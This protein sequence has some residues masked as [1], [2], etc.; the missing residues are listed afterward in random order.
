MDNFNTLSNRLLNRAPKI[1]IVLASQFIND[2]WRTLQSRRQWSW[3]R[4]SGC[5]SPPNQYSTGTATSNLAAGN[6][7]LITGSGTTW[8]VSMVGRQIRLSGYGFPYY[9]IVAVLSTTAILIDQPWAGPDQTNASYQ[10]S[11]LWYPV[12]SDWGAWYS[13]TSPK[14]GY[15]L[16]T[17]VTEDELNVLDPQRTTSGQTYVVAFKDYTSQYGGIIGPIIPVAA[18]GA[19]PVSTTSTGYSYIANATYIVKIVAGGAAGTATWAWMRAGQVAFSSTVPSDADFAQDLDNGVQIYWPAG[20]YVANDLFVIN[21]QALVASGV[22]R[23]ELWPTPNTTGY[24][25]PYTYWAKEYDLTPEAPQLPGFVANRGEVL[26]QM[27]LEQCAL[28]PGADGANPYFNLTL[29]GRHASKA[30]ELINDL[31]RND[32]EVGVSNIEYQPYPFFPAP[33]ETGQWQQSHAPY[34][35]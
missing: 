9:T 19:S 7:T 17:T 12:P 16:W 23:H 34:L 33:W 29:A 28:T 11:Q 10:I 14:D 31:E 18:V 4:R 20:I 21:C 30:M 2:A 22:P 6:P 13:I 32:E 24:L 8:T 25:Y 26:L 1:G 5:F 35:R 27:A 15:R 3:R